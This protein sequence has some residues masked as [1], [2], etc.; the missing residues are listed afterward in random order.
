VVADAPLLRY[1]IETQDEAERV[2]RRYSVS[3]PDED[4]AREIVRQKELKYVGS[5]LL[6]P[7]KEVWEDPHLH[8]SDDALVDLGRWDTFEPRSSEGRAFAGEVV[9][10][11]YKASVKAAEDRIRDLQSRVRVKDGKIVE[12]DLGRYERARLMAHLQDA[13]FKIVDVRQVPQQEIDHQRMV[14]RFAELLREADPS[15]DPRSWEKI[16]TKLRED[17]HDTAAVTASLYG[18]PTKNRSDGTT[19]GQV[20]WS[21]GG[22]TFKVSL[23][24][25]TY[26]PNQD[27]DDFFND[28]TNEI[29]GTGYT[30]G[31]ATLGTLASS[32]DGTTDQARFDA[33]DTSWTT[34]TLTARRAVIYK[35][36]GTAS[37]S[38]LI[39]WVDFGADVSTT[40]GTFQITWDATGVWLVDVT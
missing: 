7:S 28:P 16:L 15:T 33:A 23:H 14:R 11:D 12:H 1:D 8:G 3:A 29:T 19:N 32:Y 40:A 9:K 2:P 37:T 35:S 21:S 18:V 34:S 27:T 31:G 5:S 24:L 17:G 38:P 10:L 13:P 30:A 4:A 36:T 25:N 39:G 6:P 22:D 26:S 20:N